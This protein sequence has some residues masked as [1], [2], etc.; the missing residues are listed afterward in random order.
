LQKKNNY[1]YH[2]N[3][4]KTKVIT[5]ELTGQSYFS[6]EGH[7]LFCHRL[8][9]TRKINLMFRQSF[10]FPK[11][12]GTIIAI[13]TGLLLLIVPVTQAASYTY[14]DSA[15]ATFIADDTCPIASVTRVVNVPDNFIITDLNFG[16]N[17]IHPVRANIEITLQSPLGTSVLVVD[18]VAVDMNDNFVVLLD[19]AS[20]NPLND[21][22]NDTMPG[23]APFYTRTAAPNNPLSAFNGENAQGNWNITIC[24]DFVAN[25]GTYERSS[26][27]FTGT[28]VS[29]A[30]GGV[31]EMIAL[32]TASTSG[33]G[34]LVGLASVVMLV[35]AGWLL[36]R[37]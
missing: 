28:P 34:Y 36:K 2:F 4:H 18:G 30:V 20:A 9:I 1:Y 8:P 32:P 5:Y 37:R 35:G 13:I 12:P 3:Y 25:T 15:P 27:Q 10:R 17:A 19:D 16:F 23:S 6:N 14:D 31:A 7:R 33:L 21:G 22:D 24:D 29:S 11:S 26:L